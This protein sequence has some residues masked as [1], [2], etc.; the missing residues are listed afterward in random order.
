MWAVRP[1]NAAQR[2]L[3]ISQKALFQATTTRITLSVLRLQI[4]KAWK[5]VRVRIECSAVVLFRLLTITFTMLLQHHKICAITEKPCEMGYKLVLFTKRNRI[6]DSDWYQHQWPWM[7]LNGITIADARYVFGSWTS[8]MEMWQNNVLKYFTTYI[9]GRPSENSNWRQ[10]LYLR[11]CQHWYFNFL[12][13]QLS[14]MYR[15]KNLNEN[16]NLCI[17]KQTRTSQITHLSCKSSDSCVKL[18]PK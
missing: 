1:I 18:S 8:C 11:K 12:Y 4:Y 5:A 3:N 14:K 13:Y 10:N 9:C 17:M 2:A 7:T 15:W 16:K 6:P